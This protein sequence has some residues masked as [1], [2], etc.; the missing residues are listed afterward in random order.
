[1]TSRPF[2]RKNHKFKR[3]LSGKWCIGNTYLDNAH[4]VGKFIEIIMLI[5]VVVFSWE[6]V[7]ISYFITDVPLLWQQ[8]FF[9]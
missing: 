4:Q 7:R 9:C 1:M 2:L 5:N 3:G 8:K 6:K